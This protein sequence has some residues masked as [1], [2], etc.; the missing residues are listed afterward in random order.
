M[1]A[2]S[3]YQC[4]DYELCRIRFVGVQYV[5]HSSS[6]VWFITFFLFDACDGKYLCFVF[7]RSQEDEATKTDHAWCA[8]TLKRLREVSPLSLKVSLRSVSFF[9]PFFIPPPPDPVF[10]KKGKGNLVCLWCQQFKLY[11][12]RYEKVDIRLLTNVWLVNIGCR[13]RESLERSQMTSRRYYHNIC[14]LVVTTS[15]LWSL[16]NCSWHPF[17]VYGHEWLTGTSHQRY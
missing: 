3:V 15:P 12:T 14:L 9:H 17:R 1:G 13:F 10:S 7:I 8:S 5:Q 2:S 11:P 4:L 16:I 6:I